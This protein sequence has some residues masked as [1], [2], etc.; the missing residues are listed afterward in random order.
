MARP[1]EDSLEGQHQPHVVTLCQGFPADLLEGQR[2]PEV[3]SSTKE[4]QILP[5]ALSPG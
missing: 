2:P 1:Q 5:G 4:D 3:G